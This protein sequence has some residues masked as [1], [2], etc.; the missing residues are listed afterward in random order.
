MFTFTNNKFVLN[1]FLRSVLDKSINVWTQDRVK[2]FFVCKNN[3]HAVHTDYSQVQKRILE[4]NSR[5]YT[6][7]RLMVNEMW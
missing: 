5:N 3:S 6:N 7:A 1:E 2:L 4:H